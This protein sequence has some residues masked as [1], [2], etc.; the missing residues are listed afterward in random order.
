MTTNITLRFLS[1]VVGECRSQWSTNELIFVFFRPLRRVSKAT[2]RQWF[3]QYVDVESSGIT[4]AKSRSTSC[5]SCHFDRQFEASDSRRKAM[6]KVQAS[7]DRRSQSWTYSDPPTHPV[8]LR[9]D[10]RA[11]P[12]R[13][14]IAIPTLRQRF[15]TNC[16]YPRHKDLAFN[17]SQACHAKIQGLCKDLLDFSNFQGLFKTLKTLFEIQVLFKVFK[18]RTHPGYLSND[19]EESSLFPQKVLN[20]QMSWALTLLSQDTDEFYYK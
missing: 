3:M 6:M 8:C 7:R 15:S 12:A 20:R 11:H 13:A 18:V 10:P 2:S 14:S 9:V 1:S 16:L 17:E 5:P 19:K 4:Q